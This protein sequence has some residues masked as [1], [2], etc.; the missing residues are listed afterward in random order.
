[1]SLA[2][3][4]QFEESLRSLLEVSRN[5][6]EWEL[7]EAIPLLVQSF[8]REG[9]VMPFSKA[10]YVRRHAPRRPCL[11]GPRWYESA[12]VISRFLMLLNGVSDVQV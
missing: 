3:N 2:L 8:D 7:S 5:T 10:A 1:M 4:M 11:A 12:P 6:I 9:G